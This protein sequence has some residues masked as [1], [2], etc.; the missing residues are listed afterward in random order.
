[1]GATTTDPDAAGSESESEDSSGPMASLAI[2]GST[3]L[4]KFAW[5]LGTVAVA[6]GVSVGNL[7]S[8]I[9]YEQILKKMDG[10]TAV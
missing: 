10:A 7:V 2:L 1:M 4:G 5:P 9:P 6:I 3:I 8:Q